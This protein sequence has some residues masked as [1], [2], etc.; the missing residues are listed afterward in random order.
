[1]TSKCPRLDGYGVLEEIKGKSQFNS[2]PII[3]L[4]SRSNEKHKKLAFN[5]GA[6]G[7]FSKPY[8]EEELL[9]TIEKLVKV[10]YL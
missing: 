6:N 2:L 3:M 9:K 1:M 7:Y 8:N 5:L 4:T 10:N